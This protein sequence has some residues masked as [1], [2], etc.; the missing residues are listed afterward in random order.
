MAVA[1]LGDTDALVVGRE[2]SPDRQI[3]AVPAR[4]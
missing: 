3:F 1:F 2:V 4:T